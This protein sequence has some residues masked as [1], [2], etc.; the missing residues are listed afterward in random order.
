MKRIFIMFCCLFLVACSDRVPIEKVTLF[1][2]LG[3]DYD[4]KGNLLVSISAP[5]FEKGAPKKTSEETVKATSLRDAFKYI[6]AK[7]SG[8]TSNGKTEVILI[9]EKVTQQK[10]WFKE[11]DLYQR[12]PKSSNNAELVIIEGGMDEVLNVKL[13]DKLILATYLMEIIR[14]MQ[15]NNTFIPAP[16][17]TFS[18]IANDKGITATLPVIKK[19]GEKLEFQGTALL[20]ESG[21]PKVRLSL[22]ENNLLNLLRLPREKGAMSISLALPDEDAKQKNNVSLLVTD[23]KRDIDVSYTGGKFVYTINVHLHADLIEQTKMRLNKDISKLGEEAEVL[24]KQITQELDK[25]L[26]KVV[27]KF[28]EGK[29]DPIGLGQYAKAYEYNEWKKVE[30]NWGEELSKAEI[31]VNADI[32]LF[33]TGLLP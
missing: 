17:R 26:K 2:V 15:T 31:K 27:E 16:V 32:Q 25:E 21:Q 10:E 22:K 13:K 3:V 7:I 5:S 28:Q 24:N 23:L 19:V 20:N 1:L 33:T 8:I 30:D 9:G 18:N 29:V 6:N 12:D 4:D 14:S 11:I